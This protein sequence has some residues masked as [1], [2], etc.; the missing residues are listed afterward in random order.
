MKQAGKPKRRKR[1][2]PA[3]KS[4]VWWPR[5]AL[6]VERL[7]KVLKPYEWRWFKRNVKT[8]A[9]DLLDVDTATLKQ[10]FP[11]TRTGDRNQVND[12]TL[13]VTLIWQTF[14][15][16]LEKLVRPVRG[17]IRSF[18]YQHVERFYRKHGL[19]GA[20]RSTPTWPRVRWH[21]LVQGERWTRS[22]L[23]PEERTVET[24]TTAFNRFVAHSIFRFSGA[25]E[26]Q[27][28]I[29]AKHHIGQTRPGYLFFTEKEGLWWLCELL[30]TDETN[31]RACSIS[32]L[33]SNGQPSLLALE[34]FALR[35]LKRAKHLVIGVLCDFDPWGFSIAQQI[36][37]KMR[38][39]GFKSVTAYFL[40]TADLFTTE[41]KELGKDFSA[42]IADGSTAPQSLQTLVR[43]WFERTG[44]VDN[45]PLGLHIDVLSDDVKQA[46]ALAWMDAV[47]DH[48]VPPFPL[49]DVVPFPDDSAPRKRSTR[50]GKQP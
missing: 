6:E 31:P 11:P 26:I 42:I 1:T 15:K 19:L 44:G 45:K 7:K 25:F 32:V 13:I 41:Q 17:N 14:I 39:F 29:E 21:Q 4:P 50:V 30:W 34:D 16:V 20:A 33:A 18:W 9:P 36:A 10:L 12:W 40:T 3:W 23:T 2:A 49:V 8:G 47:L 24:M 48:Q 46:R 37:A 28:P 38:F 5:E 27:E 35:L 22:G 43:N